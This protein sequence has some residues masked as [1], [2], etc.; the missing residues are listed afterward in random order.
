METDGDRTRGFSFKLEEGII[1]VIV[2]RK[3]VTITE[4]HHQRAV[5][6]WHCCPELWCPIPGGTPG[7]AGWG[8]GQPELG[9]GIPAH[10]WGLGLGVL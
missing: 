2:R 6:P 4:S 10:G 7:Q 3:R 9:G 1:R 5:R 8:P